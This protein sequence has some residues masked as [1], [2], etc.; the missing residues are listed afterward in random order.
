MKKEDLGFPI[1]KF[2]RINSIKE[3][4]ASYK[5]LVECLN[6]RKRLL[7][8]ELKDAKDLTPYEVNEKRILLIKTDVDLAKTHTSIIMKEADVNDYI[9]RVIMPAIGEIDEKYESLLNNAKACAKKD[10]VM[11]K[12]MSEAKFEL[13][14]E[15]W[16]HKFNFYMAVKNYLAPPV[17]HLRRS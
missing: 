9:S 7:K 17:N 1:E 14:E 2:P 12:V 4:I 15:N 10:K 3:T 11:Q 6:T 8:A 5:E 16:E 13:F